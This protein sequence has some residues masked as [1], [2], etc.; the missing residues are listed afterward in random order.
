M[1]IKI[2]KSS[3]KG[4]PRFID[5]GDF[6]DLARIIRIRKDV[7]PTNFIDLLLLENEDKKLSEILDL[8]QNYRAKNRDFKTI[9]RLKTHIKF[10]HEN[11]GW[12][13]KYSEDNKNPIVILTGLKL[14]T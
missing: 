5:A 12:L 10:R 13:F 4:L 14:K 11:D 9:S 1:K 8:F 2:S 6:K 3:A 7:F